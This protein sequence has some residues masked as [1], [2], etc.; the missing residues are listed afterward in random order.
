[1]KILYVNPAR[2]SSGLDAIIK[3]PP[4]NLISI[5]AMVPEHEAELFDFK[6]HKYNENKFRSLLNQSDVVALTSMTP[7]IS[8]A[9]EVAEMAKD[10][11]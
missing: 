4:L 9:F 8:H 11:G 10:L 1:M 5:A 2:L 6:V 7:Q 3:G